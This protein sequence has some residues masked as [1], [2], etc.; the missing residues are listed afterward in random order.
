[1]SSRTCLPVSLLAWRTTRYRRSAMLSNST[2]RV[3]SN[4]RCNSRDW[5]ACAARLSSLPSTA[6][7]RLRCT[8]A[9]SLTDSAIMRVSSCMRVKRSN[10]SGSKFCCAS[11]DS[12]R[13]DCICVSACS[14]TSRSCARRR[15]RLPVSSLSRP[16]S[17]P[18]SVSSRAREVAT[19]PACNTRRS[20]SCERTRTAWLAAARADTSDRA[21]GDA[22]SPG[23]TIGSAVGS[24]TVSR[25]D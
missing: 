21:A 15:S 12:A 24:G 6:R 8:V 1:M 4:S 22:T 10:S 5:R 3:R 13:R 7:C 2:M 14:S 20:S 19:S 23:A 16:R 18:T 17:W 25:A 9:T 11:L